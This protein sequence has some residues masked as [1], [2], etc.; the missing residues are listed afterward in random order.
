M[1]DANKPAP[2]KKASRIV[3]K[4]RATLVFGGKF[5]PVYDELQKRA[6]AADRDLDNYI[7]VTLRDHVAPVSTEPA[8]A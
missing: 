3:N 5:E 4:R 8:A 6:E 1:A 2:A 7:L